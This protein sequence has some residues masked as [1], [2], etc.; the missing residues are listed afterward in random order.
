MKGLC[1]A[2]QERDKCKALAKLQQNIIAAHG[3]T[4]RAFSASIGKLGI[5]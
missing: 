4:L 5:I 3:G 1:A 2:P